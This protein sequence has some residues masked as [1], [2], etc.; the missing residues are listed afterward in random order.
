MKEM[1]KKLS[2]EFFIGLFFIFGLMVLFY[3]TVLIDGENIFASQE[4]F[5]YK[6]SFE[7]V[8]EL[9]ANDKVYIRGMKIG[10][11]KSVEM[12]ENF[13]NVNVILTLDK[14][15]PFYPG[16]KIK[17]KAASLFGGQVITIA[18]GDTTKTK[19]AKNVKLIGVPYFDLMAEAAEYVSQLKDGNLIENIKKAAEEL[20]NGA[21]NFSELTDTI[22]SGN[23]TMSKI[24]N[25]SEMHDETIAMVDEIKSAATRLEK[26]INEAD[27]K[28]S[29]VFEDVKNGKGTLGKL[30]KDETLYNDAKDMVATIE[31]AAEKMKKFG[32]KLNEGEGTLHKLMNEDDVYKDAK[33]LVNTLNDASENMR[34]ITQDFRDGKG[35][36][37]KF[38]TDEEL[39]N[40]LKGT[41]KQ[42]RAA[43]EDYREQAP[44][45]TFGSLVFGAL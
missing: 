4:F 26:F 10:K 1:L 24:I 22:K 7:Q 6:V 8:G 15:V 17:I 38:I 25:T 29:E 5:D 43:I 39:Y 28:M 3:F 16:Y 30:V 31:E 40:D 11:V 35:T 27:E 42:L 32:T 33:K 18:L 45:S 13:E 12:D 23:G 44:I 36:L 2:L 37:G 20:K 34:S 14:D 21:R 41:I 19:I 9:K